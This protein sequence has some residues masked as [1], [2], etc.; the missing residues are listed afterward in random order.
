MSWVRRDLK[1]PSSSNYLSYIGTLPS[2]SAQSPT[3][4]GLKHLQGRGIQLLRA[5]CTTTSLPSFLYLIYIYS[6]KFKGIMPCP[7]TT[8]LDRVSLPSSPGG[9]FRY[10]KTVRAAWNLLPAEQPQ[11]SQPLFAGK[12]F[13][14]NEYPHGS[15]LS[16]LQQLHV[17]ELGAQTQI[18][19]SR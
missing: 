9:S 18:K 17:L 16:L 3:Q 8:L 1:W 5:V 12:V 7:I 6:V 14:P 19:Y 13:Q 4:P 10:W 15:P 2:R 11:L